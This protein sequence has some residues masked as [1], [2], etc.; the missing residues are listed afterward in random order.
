MT[1]AMGS[2][3]STP[4]WKRKKFHVRLLRLVEE[5]CSIYVDALDEET[6]EADALDIADEI[7][8]AIW[9][10]S[11]SEP[12]TLSVESVKLADPKQT[13]E[14]KSEEAVQSSLDEE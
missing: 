11:D 13:Q 12:H 4:K 7:A 9:L 6:A 10:R 2:T 3:G 8:E 1:G 5:E 14:L